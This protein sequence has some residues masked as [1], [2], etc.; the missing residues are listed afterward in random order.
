VTRND[1]YEQYHRWL[2]CR[3][4][5]LAEDRPFSIGLEG[6]D[7]GICTE[8]GLEVAKYLCDVDGDAPGGWLFFGEDIVSR[9]ATERG[10]AAL[11]EA[12]PEIASRSYTPCS[13]RRCGFLSDVTRLGGAV[14]FLP[15]ACK[16][17]RNHSDLFVAGIQSGGPDGEGGSDVRG[18]L[19]IDLERIGRDTAIRVIADSALEWALA[20]PG[21]T[22][23]SVADDN[24]WK[25]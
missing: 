7:A 17:L 8:I 23:S 24:P 25:S 14:L 10:I 6:S 20:R 2:E 22:P 13:E 11:A 21:P 19:T 18:D 3:R 12:F 1:A 15:H 16:S 9:V 5:S 4:W